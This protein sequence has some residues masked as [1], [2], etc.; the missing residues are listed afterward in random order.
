MSGS[1]PPGILSGAPTS[2]PYN[3]RAISDLG[4]GRLGGGST[5][6]AAG[7][8]QSA[9]SDPSPGVQALGAVLA[10]QRLR[11]C[12]K[13]I[14]VQFSA[15]SN[16]GVAGVYGFYQQVLPGNPDRKLLIISAPFNNGD[17]ETP[18]ISYAFP[19]PGGTGF[20]ILFA[21]GNSILQPINSASQLTSL[22][23]QLYIPLTG[24]SYQNV[25]LDNPPIA[26]VTIVCWQYSPGVGF[27]FNVGC[28][29]L[30]GS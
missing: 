24:G 15:P 29:I 26:P 2:L 25:V 17:P 7:I 22:N 19:G 5:E 8:Q 28:S 1:N 9:L 21:A 27:K 12:Q 23:S 20:G 10:T 13:I 4:P 6:V 3:A 14:S 11:N 16:P 18:M 30:E